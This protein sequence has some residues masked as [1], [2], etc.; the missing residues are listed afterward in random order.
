MSSSLA[1]SGSFG[2]NNNIHADHRPA[3]EA[4]GGSTPAAGSKAQQQQLLGGIAKSSNNISSTATANPTS[5]NNTSN[6]GLNRS[7]LTHANLFTS[8]R[9]ADNH[10]SNVSS[11][12]A[13]PASDNLTLTKN[14]S[15]TISLSTGTNINASNNNSNNITN[16]L[17][18]GITNITRTN[19]GGNIAS[20]HIASDKNNN[21]SANGGVRYRE[22]LKNHAAN[23]GGYAVDG[24][25]EFMPSGEEGSLEALKCAACGC[26][27]NFHR[28][29]INGSSIGATTSNSMSLL[30]LPSTVNASNT[31]TSN[32]EYGEGDHNHCNTPIAGSGA[33]APFPG[34]YN[35]GHM[36]GSLLPHL[37]HHHHHQY[38]QAWMGGKLMQPVG[39]GPGGPHAGMHVHHGAHAAGTGGAG[40]YSYMGM[41]PPGI[42][43]GSGVGG[44]GHH[45]MH[46]GGGHGGGK[47]F[48][49]KF[50]MEQREKMFEFSEKVGWRIHKHDEAAV[51]QFCAE[52][53]VKRHV[54]KVWMHN[55]KNTFGKKLLR[56]PEAFNALPES[57]S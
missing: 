24:C 17:A 36:G 2:D 13:A 15:S 7:S 34:H 33:A 28:R 6:N 21:S 40:Q 56:F 44:A 47:R 26:H 22:C 25:G 27:R 1:M 57:S 19:S 45:Y 52:A 38:M 41:G 37:H 12:Q 46:A 10:I 43:S 4:T 42:G 29:E 54:L 50:T 49:T 20:S 55:N 14:N 8:T 51:Q 5:S 39:A 23:M 11:G 32:S 3:G 35:A 48:R 18:S 16:N 9:P 53:G 31:S 30:A